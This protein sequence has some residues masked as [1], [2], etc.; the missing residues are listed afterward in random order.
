MKLNNKNGCYDEY[1]CELA[2]A[3]DF[4]VK[5]ENALETLGINLYEKD[6]VTYKSICQLSKE[7]AQKWKEA[8]L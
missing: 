6:G 1:V 5:L 3:S 2:E 7:I 8:V 4:I